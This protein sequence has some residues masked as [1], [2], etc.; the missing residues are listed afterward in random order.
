V[1]DAHSY[2][3]TPVAAPKKEALSESDDATDEDNSV[4]TVPS[5]KPKPSRGGTGANAHNEVEKRRRAYLT[6]CYTELHKILPQISGTKASNATVLLSATDY[7]KVRRGW[8]GVGRRKWADR[9]G[10]PLL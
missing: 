6:A 4:P 7:I 10:G 1:T 8:T 2:Y 3:H 5:A 9:S